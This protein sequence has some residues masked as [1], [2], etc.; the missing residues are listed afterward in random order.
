[1]N[2]AL[3]G[4][5]KMDDEM[6]TE[7]TRIHGEMAARSSGSIATPSGEKENK[8]TPLLN[9]SGHIYRNSLLLGVGYLDLTN[10]LDFPANVWNQTPIPIYAKVLMGLGGSIALLAIG[11][12]VWDMVRCWRNI[13]FLR[14]E[15]ACLLQNSDR[16]GLVEKA[17][18]SINSRELCWE[19]IDR[20]LL[21]FFMGLTGL[22]VGAGTL[23]AMK[24]DNKTIFNVSNI[25]SGYLGNSFLAFYA[26]IN[27]IWSGIMWYRAHAN[28][29]A[30]RRSKLEPE[31]ARLMK[32]HACKHQMYALV[33][34]TTLV[35]SGVASMVSA[36]IWQGYI[37][38]A[39]CVMASLFV[40][41]Y[42]RFC[43]GYDRLSFQQRRLPG[44]MDLSVRLRAI[45]GVRAALQDKSGRGTADLVHIVGES[46]E[47]GREPVEDLLHDLG[48]KVSFEAMLADSARSISGHQDEFEPSIDGFA[49]AVNSCIQ[50]AGLR[51]VKHEERFLLELYGYYLREKENAL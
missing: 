7:K 16:M 47:K 50:A 46:G 44:Y 43:L 31:L 30:V 45:V 2:E 12:A 22:F 36:T 42:W 28:H 8:T 15:R 13:S 32:F 1:M 26:L 41:H 34:G 39:P 33:N 40:V 23:L 49:A 21:D 27:S 6:A 37:V 10:A 19:I 25:L 24:G 35:V 51:R 17:W 5:V 38:Q 48:L 3:Y 29:A 20:F 4:N 18:L 14:G 9:P 11:I